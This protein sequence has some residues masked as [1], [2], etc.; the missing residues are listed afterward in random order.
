MP[1]V[2]FRVPRWAACAMPSAGPYSGSACLTSGRFDILSTECNVL[3]RPHIIWPCVV[4]S[5]Y[6]DYVFCHCIV[7]G[8]IAIVGSE[9]ES[10]TRLCKENICR[11]QTFDC[12]HVAGPVRL[13]CCTEMVQRVQQQP[14]TGRSTLQ[15]G[16]QD[17]DS[18]MRVVLYHDIHLRFPSVLVHALPDQA[19]EGRAVTLYSLCECSYA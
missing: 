15:Y 18:R 1:L 6:L 9:D 8:F 17:P 12:A 16:N 14:C 2:I 3:N 11:S 19:T 7:L 13:F 5:M 10:R 4:C